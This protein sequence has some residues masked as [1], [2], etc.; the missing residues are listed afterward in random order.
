[1]VLKAGLMAGAGLV[2]GAPWISRAAGG[3]SPNEKLNI[4]G[5]GIGDMGFSNLKA[6]EGENIVALCDVD[7]AYAAKVRGASRLGNN[8]RKG[9]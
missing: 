2:C 8:L 1:M 3:R 7:A 9:S 5:V 4:A 6:C